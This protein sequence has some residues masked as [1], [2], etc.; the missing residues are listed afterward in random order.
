MSLTSTNVD[1]D[2]RFSAVSFPDKITTPDLRSDL[3]LALTRIPVFTSIQNRR[4]RHITGLAV[5]NLTPFPKRDGVA[6]TLSEASAASSK[7]I[8]QAYIPD[9]A[10]LILSQRRTRKIS[11]TSVATLRTLRAQDDLGIGLSSLGSGI[12]I[13]EDTTPTPTRARRSS[14]A[15]PSLALPPPTSAQQLRRGRSSSQVSL[16]NHL[17]HGQPSSP[18]SLRSPPF[19]I[20]LFGSLAQYHHLTPSSSNPGST[21]QRSLEKVL[22]TRLVE[23]LFTLSPS[24]DTQCGQPEKTSAT[25]VPLVKSSTTSS[26]PRSRS[27]PLPSQRQRAHVRTATSVSRSGHLQSPSSSSLSSRLSSSPATPRSTTPTPPSAPTTSPGP[28]YVS[29]GHRPSTNPTWVGVDPEHEFSPGANG[30]AQK[31]LV[32]LWA[33]IEDTASREA[34]KKSGSLDLSGKGKAKEDDPWDISSSWQPVQQW[35][36]DLS[37]AEQLPEEYEINPHR[38]PP[39]SL[40]IALGQPSKWYWFPPTK[41]SR[42]L[43]RADGHISDGDEQRQTGAN[44]V[45]LN[46]PTRDRFN[47]PIPPSRKGS[48]IRTS[49]PLQDIIKLVTLESVLS[50]TEGSTAAVL[51]NV[52]KVILEDGRSVLAREESERGLYLAGLRG[53]KDGLKAKSKSARQAIQRRRAALEARREALEQG[54]EFLEQDQASSALKRK[55]VDV[56]Q[57]RLLD[58]NAQLNAQRMH[59]IRT[60]DFIF[61]IEP[62]SSQDLLFGILE[63]PLPLPIGSSDP[64]PPLSLPAT[65]GVNEQTTATA[66]GYVAQLMSDKN[67]RALDM[68]HTLPNLKNLLL[69][70]TNGTSEELTP[71]REPQRAVAPRAIDVTEVWQAMDDL[72]SSTGTPETASPAPSQP[73]HIKRCL[74]LREWES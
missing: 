70:L 66:L 25:S 68:R 18:S 65:P 59:L 53:A 2:T 51:A 3:G 22:Q 7:G 44:G 29:N 55:E 73:A 17:P 69:T 16:L 26:L 8:E 11:S 60:L 10:D 45:R 19:D 67:L 30:R 49:A 20:S 31:V 37:D 42:H 33:R 39:N 23:T 46:S 9:D 57:N 24:D 13:A 50:D 1:D 12:P 5:R 32:T 48:R 54:L 61:P 14:K 40:V 43:S 71:S 47:K 27:P 58:A 38:L 64:A 52:D 56:A 63:I 72:P 4:I 21:L 28:F 41:T 6:S 34:W 35:D 36:V 62:L 74:K 15:R